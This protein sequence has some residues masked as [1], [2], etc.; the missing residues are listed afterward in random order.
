VIFRAVKVNSRA[1]DHFT[2]QFSNSSVEQLP[3]CITNEK[4]K[5]TVGK[6]NSGRD[7]VHYDI[8]VMFSNA[9]LTC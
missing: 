3:V 5:R 6:L 7:S 9:R 2:S 1:T 8:S 4:V